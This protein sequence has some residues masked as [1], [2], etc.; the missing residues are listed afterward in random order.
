MDRTRRRYLDGFATGCLVLLYDDL[1][2]HEIVESLDYDRGG[3]W[4]SVPGVA[5]T[6]RPSAPRSDADGY[7]RPPSRRPA[8]R[9]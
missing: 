7:E 8:R 4:T 2:V 1:T 5:A 3:D 6:K 9:S